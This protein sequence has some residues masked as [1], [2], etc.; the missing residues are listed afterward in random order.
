MFN[1]SLAT[2]NST[3]IKCTYA[4]PKRSDLFFYGIGMDEPVSLEDIGSRYSLT[5]ERVR[6]IKDKAPNKITYCIQDVIC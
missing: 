6:Q 1:D 3:F 5:R 2:G 4:A